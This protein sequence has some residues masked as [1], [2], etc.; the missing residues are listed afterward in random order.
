MLNAGSLSSNG[1]NAGGGVYIDGTGANATL[2]S[3]GIVGNEAL[4]DGGGFYLVGGSLE[5][6]G[7]STISGNTA[8][9]GNGGVDYGYLSIGPDCLITDEIVPTW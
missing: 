3:V 2:I 1:A 7:Y 4:T 6:A 9:Y 8:N 5:L